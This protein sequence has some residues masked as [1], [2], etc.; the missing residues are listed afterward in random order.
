MTTATVQ[1]PPSASRP[2]PVHVDVANEPTAS[3]WLWLVKWVLAI[4]HYVVLALLWLAFGVLSIV[5]FFAILVTGRYPRAIFDFNVGVLRCSWR[6][7]YY[8]YGALATD[9][10]PP[11]TLD[12]VADYPAHLDVD[13]PEHLSRGLVL[14]KWWLLA[15]PHSIVVAIIIGSSGWVA[16]E[17]DRWPI[18][19]GG[20]LLG[21]LALV[22][23]VVLGATGSYPRPLYDLLLGLNR[24][25]LRVGAYV[26][27]MTDEYPPFRLDQGPHEPGGSA[28]STHPPVPGAVGTD[29]SA[30]GPA[31]GSPGLPRRT[32]WTVG[33]IVGVVAGSCAVLLSLVLLPGG[34]TLLVADNVARDGGY[35]TTVE[36]PVH[37]SGYAVA[38]SSVVLDAPVAT[39]NVPARF[40]GDVRIRVTSTRPGVPVFVGIAPA[41]QVDGYLAG[42]ARSE[43]AAREVRDREIAG[44]APASTPS[45]QGFWVD[46]AS[47]TGAQE[48]VWTP[49]VGTWSVVLMNADASAGV[50]A[51]VSAGA[52]LPWL[53]T[54]GVV[55]IIIGA[56]LL[57]AG[58][59]LVARCVGLA[60]RG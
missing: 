45:S 30:T 29:A 23:G 26:G 32:G 7:A 47:G 14:V 48:L 55:L 59:A 15:I 27:L 19:F 10:Y 58:V 54:V 60:S 44:G 6:V 16:R 25:V 5:A 17:A 13:Y 49:T 31:P 3:R 40:L 20:G 22:A 57:A 9:E 1:R 41:S 37:S 24:W 43:P 21:I 33:R 42:V 2:Y 51:S 35:V 18:V 52:T 39:A 8:S 12:D 46:T 11:F 56:L 34:G 50:A 36:R 4:P 28:V 53:G 38:M